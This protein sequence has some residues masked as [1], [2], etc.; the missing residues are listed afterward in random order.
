[1][2]NI[3][4]SLPSIKD[5]A[6]ETNKHPVIDIDALALALALALDHYARESSSFSQP[7]SLPP[8]FKNTIYTCVF[9]IG[10]QYCGRKD[11]F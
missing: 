2:I 3:V 9:I 1:M 6:R 4:S 5:L 10:Q 7:V 8:L 11:N